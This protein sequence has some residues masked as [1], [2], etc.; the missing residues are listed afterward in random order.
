ML[1][2]SIV[3]NAGEVLPQAPPLSLSDNPVHIS[4]VTN[5]PGCVEDVDI[6]LEEEIEQYMSHLAEEQKNQTLV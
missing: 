6:E 4:D 3:Q 1:S 2:P 5:L